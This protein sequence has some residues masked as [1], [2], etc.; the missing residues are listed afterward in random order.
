VSGAA[1]V[2]E[3]LHRQY[4]INRNMTD[5]SLLRAMNLRLYQPA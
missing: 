5:P 1:N 2:E 4:G 3:C